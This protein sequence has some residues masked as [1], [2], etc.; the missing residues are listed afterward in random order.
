MFAVSEDDKTRSE[1]D[2]TRSDIDVMGQPAIVT[3]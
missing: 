2:K 3:V 1:D